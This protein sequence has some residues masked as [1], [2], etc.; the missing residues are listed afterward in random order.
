MDALECFSSKKEISPGRENLHTT[1]SKEGERGGCVGTFRAID[2]GSNKKTRKRRALSGKRRD[3]RARAR[4]TTA[5]P[6]SISWTIYIAGG[7]GWEPDETESKE[8]AGKRE[9]SKWEGVKRRR[10]GGKRRRI[11][12]EKGS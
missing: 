4:T 10:A 12:D 11:T 8:R 2:W 9:K 3:K 6:R 7:G 5:P 1:R